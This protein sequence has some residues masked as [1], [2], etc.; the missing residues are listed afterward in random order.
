MV[1]FSNIKLLIIDMDNTLCD[2]FHTLSKQQWENVA[3][4]FERKGWTKQAQLLRKN[5]GK[6][7]FVHTLA[8]A[9]F[10]DEE[11]KYAVKIYDQ[12]D[13][14][15]LKLY[16]DAHAIMEVNIPKV[17]VTRGEKSLQIK[18]IKRIGVRKY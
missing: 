1:S 2:T 17:L 16:P 18:K 15:P 10:T 11:R 8:R 13:V 7:G 14:K 6:F 3:K 5:L 4:A 9:D 12:V